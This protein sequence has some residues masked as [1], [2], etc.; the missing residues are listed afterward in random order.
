MRMWKEVTLIAWMTGGIYAQTPEPTEFRPMAPWPYTMEQ[1]V[2]S[3]SLSGGK[4]GAPL[5]GHNSFGISRT[6][7]SWPR[8]EDCWVEVSL[9]TGKWLKIPLM[10]ARKSEEEQEDCP[11]CQVW[12][13]V[14][15]P[16]GRVMGYKLYWEGVF[17][18]DHFF[19]GASD[20]TVPSIRAWEHKPNN[21]SWEVRDA[22]P[23]WIGGDYVEVTYSRDFGSHW[24]LAGENS[25]KGATDFK[26]F[27]FKSAQHL[28]VIRFEVY[29][30]TRRFVAYWSMEKHQ[31]VTNLQELG[32]RP[33][34]VPS[35]TIPVK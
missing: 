25:A 14:F 4:H 33:G 3:G 32:V 26:D 9:D 15:A 20:T 12:Q 10:V 24:Y 7:M 8:R 34:S 1:V 17:R 5:M 6:I 19:P 21:I 22:G 29:R 30:G 18:G 35:G 28:L 2:M 13:A 23:H 31:F 16:S 27:V 11:E